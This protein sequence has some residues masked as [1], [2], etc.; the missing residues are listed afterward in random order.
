MRTSL[1][2]C[3]SISVASLLSAAASAATLTVGPNGGMYATPCEAVAAAADNDVIEIDAAGTYE[4]N[5]CVIDKAGLTLKGT[6]AGRA[7]IDAKL[8]P[9]DKLPTGNA[10]WVVTSDNVIIENVEITGAVDAVNKTGAAIHQTTGKG[11]TITGC[12]IHDNDSGVLVDDGAGASVTIDKSEL[13]NNGINQG[14]DPGHITVGKIAKLTLTSS[15]LH[16]GL[17][18]TMVKSS[19]VE[20]HILYNR[21]TSES[22]GVSRSSL[23]LPLGGLTY[24]IGNVFHRAQNDDDTR[25]IL[26]AQGQG[27]LHPSKELFIINNTFLSDKP[28]IAVDTS[29]DPL[30]D[31]LP[32]VRNNIF[33]IPGMADLVAPKEAL[34]VN[35]F[36][37]DPLFVDQA[38]FDLH[39]KE[40]S[41]CVDKGDPPGVGAGLDLK[42]M[43][44]YMHIAQ[45]EDRPVDDPID[46]GAYEIPPPVMG[47][48]GGGAGG[49]GGSSNDGGG[50]SQGSG[51]GSSSASSGSGGASSGGDEGC[52]C[53]VGE[54]DTPKPA[55]LIAFGVALLYAARR[56]RGRESAKG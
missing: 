53:R 50:G 12:S 23:D 46:V 43:S 48:G 41:P 42:P 7:K 49:M 22:D 26:Y 45:I 2:T 8:D 51:G 16:H 24:V 10:V 9:G 56:R 40:N 18:V 33:A 38:N 30:A 19:A 37:G 11:L 36:K 4:K 15:Y 13:F 31:P 32:A 21:I 5:Y 52:G 1:L 35:N 29:L 25:M 20:T 27:Q 3:A 17:H 14:D 44:Q 34:E 47:T 54:A 39:L 55:A 6:G 28:A